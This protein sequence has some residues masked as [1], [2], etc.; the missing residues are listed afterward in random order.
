M[1]GPVGRGELAAVILW[2]TLFAGIGL[3][4]VNMALARMAGKSNN[5]GS[6]TNTAIVTALT[7]ASATSIIGYL[8]LPV[9]LSTEYHH[10][11][12]LSYFFLYFIPLNH[13]AIVIQG[14]DHGA[15][16]FLLYNLT[17]IILNPVYL[18]LLIGI[19]ITGN[20][21]LEMIIGVLIFSNGVVVIV[22]LWM[23]RND[24]ITT[25]KIESLPLVFK[26]ATQFGMTN[27][28]EILFQRIDQV[29]LLWLLTAE[30]FGYYVVALAAASVIA[31]IPHSIGT[32][33]FTQA[34]RDIAKQNF[35]IIAASFRKA[36]IL[37][38][39]AG[40][41]LLLM[42]PIIFPLIFGKEFS[43]G[44]PI[45]ML[46]TVGVLFSGLSQ[47]IIH[48]FRGQGYPIK[49]FTGK[50]VFIIV[51]VISAYILSHY[52]ALPGIAIAFILGQIACF[53]ILTVLLLKHYSVLSLKNIVPSWEDAKYITHDIKRLSEKIK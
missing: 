29:I 24:I 7:T 36:V 20:V 39:A 26:N 21:S 18:L 43:A 11:L 17:R 22:R 13:I 2:P 5:P 51:F 1:L 4:G 23:K 16:N 32:V 6:L 14:I 42:L 3:F 45:A 19:W 40:L 28:G 50:I 33:N 8:L 53:V 10:L 12:P 30:D 25:R 9:V 48:V 41:A 27:I 31:S 34:A 49:G 15:G 37:T 46:L 38:I 44:V 35:D 52:L 47:I